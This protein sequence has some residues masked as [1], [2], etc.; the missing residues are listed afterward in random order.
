[1]SSYLPTTIEYKSTQLEMIETDEMTFSV[2]S[3]SEGNRPLSST[4]EHES[5][6]DE[7]SEGKATSLDQHNE[8]V[9]QGD[10][11]SLGWIV[12]VDLKQDE[13]V[14]SS[15]VL[16]EKIVHVQDS[17]ST[18]S[19]S[20]DEEAS[21]AS[22]TNQ[23]LALSDAEIVVK[24][25]PTDGARDV[26]LPKAPP[27]LLGAKHKSRVE[28]DNR[29]FPN[30]PKQLNR[31]RTS[32]PSPANSENKPVHRTQPTAKRS[33]QT[34]AQEDG[35]VEKRLSN[36]Q[37][38]G[39]RRSIHSN[40]D[41]YNTILL[42][43]S[44][45][46][47]DLLS[48]F[49]M[50]NDQITSASTNQ[51]RSQPRRGGS[52]PVKEQDK[53]TSEL[54]QY[55]YGSSAQQ[56]RKKGSVSSS[57]N[58]E[59]QMCTF[60][61]RDQTY[62]SPKT[63]GSQSIVTTAGRQQQRNHG[64]QKSPSYSVKSEPSFTIIDN[65]NSIETRSGFSMLIMVLRASVVIFCTFSFVARAITAFAGKVSLMDYLVDS[66]IVWTVRFYISVLHISLILVELS[67]PIPG[68]LPKGTLDNFLHRGFIQSF[69]GVLDVCLNTSKTLAS[70]GLT[71]KK[72]LV[73]VAIRVLRVT[74][75]GLIACGILYILLGV[76][77]YNGALARRIAKYERE[78]EAMPSGLAKKR[79][80]LS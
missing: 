72:K 59:V 38:Q 79:L 4:N 45:S 19:V 6:N 36:N 58:E 27:S 71:A 44:Q 29:L 5:T 69:I 42:H 31:K 8:E 77:G 30:S 73:N 75:R 65:S 15:A 3:S 55:S 25:L 34:I 9:K 67:V 66:P 2:A 70:D 54:S 48:S 37:L 18:G 16:R 23:C 20:V 76:C 40:N 62:I 35:Y 10:T 21:R 41:K 68:L 50:Y 53:R 32:R 17:G 28:S 14:E 12:A 43:Q 60:D 52:R 63:K 22:N 46:N 57:R 49:V 51:Q 26:V 61:G 47:E 78:D 24:P 11:L 1:M 39:R 7:L 56:A 33:K 74:P 13:R 80:S 64:L